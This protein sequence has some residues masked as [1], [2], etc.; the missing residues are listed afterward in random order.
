VPVF[1]AA[2]TSRPAVVYRVVRDAP[3]VPVLLRWW[4]DSPPG[5]LDALRRLVAE[6]YARV[7]TRP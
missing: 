6:E 2:G 1:G 3:P 4:A 7:G 5:E